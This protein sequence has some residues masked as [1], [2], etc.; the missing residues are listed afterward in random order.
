MMKR[1]RRAGWLAALALAFAAGAPVG[2]ATATGQSTSG[3]PSTSPA[4][5]PAASN[6]LQQQ[7]DLVKKVDALHWQ[8]GPGPA[9]VADNATIALP[10]GFKFLGPPESSTYMQLQ[11][12]PPADRD[13]IFSRDDNAS[14]AVF[15]FDSSGYVK[16]DEKID[17]DA[18]LKTLKDQNT[19]DIAQRR[20][21]N[22]PTLTLDGWYV[23]PHYDKATNRLE[24]GTRLTESD[25]SPVVDYTVRVLGRSGVMSVTL[26]SDPAHF[27]DDLA[28]FKQSLSTFQF[29]SGETYAEY[30]PGD[31]VAEYGLGA[32][33]VGGAAAVAVKAGV[34]FLKFIWVAVVG[35][36]ASIAA[37]FRRLFG[38]KTPK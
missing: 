16:D 2:L 23:P 5:S 1:S 31:K 37:F 30:K 21:M 6:Q 15:A 10:K 13:H 29:N 38:R 34:P 35:A 22:M 4:D 17:P 7:I 20:Q 9:T 36:G 28:A 24:W 27:N 18:L 33:V 3:G 26:V 8:E 25:N 14:F 32:L 12:N 19:Q 11:Q